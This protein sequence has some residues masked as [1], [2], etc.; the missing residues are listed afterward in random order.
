MFIFFLYICV[1]KKNQI[2]DVG[3]NYLQVATKWGGGD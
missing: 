1:K 3:L 2:S